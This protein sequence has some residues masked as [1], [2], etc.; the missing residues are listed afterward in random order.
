MQHEPTYP[1][2]ERVATAMM[3]LSVAGLLALF[4]AWYDPPTTPHASARPVLARD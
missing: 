4:A 1:V 2:L 3:V